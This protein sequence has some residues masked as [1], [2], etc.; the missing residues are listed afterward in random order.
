MSAFYEIYCWDASLAIYDW[1]V[2]CL[3][4]PNAIVAA[5]LIIRASYAAMEGKSCSR[6]FGLARCLLGVTMLCY[7]LGVVAMFY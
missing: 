6:M 4:G 7:L 1:W 3:R 5:E 2:L